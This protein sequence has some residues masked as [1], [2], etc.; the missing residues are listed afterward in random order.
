MSDTIA[1]VATAR[2]RAALGIIRLSGEEAVSVAEAVFRPQKGGT[3]RDYGPHRL[4]LG[5]AVDE[6]D[7]VLDQVLCTYALAPRSFTGEDTAELQCHGSPAALQELLRTLL[8]QGARMAGPGEFSRRA[9]LNGRLDLSQAE[10]IMDLIDAETPLGVRNAALQLGGAVTR[11]TEKVYELLL[12]LLAHFQAVV[13]YP[14]EG[15]EPLEAAETAATLEEAAGQLETLRRS[16]E[17]GKLLKEGVKC[18]IL[19]RPNAGKSSLLN[20]LLGYERAIVTDEA[21]TTR[22][23][24]EEKLSLGGLLL[25]L[26]DTAGLRETYS[27]AEAEGVRRAEAAAEGAGLVLAVFDASRPL[28]PED[29]RVMAAAAAA[30]LSLAVLNKADLPRC[31]DASALSGQFQALVSLSA[32]TGEG[33]EDLE[34]AIV[35]LLGAEDPLPAGEIL[36]NERQYDAI[37]RAQEAIDRAAAALREGFTPDAVLTDAEEALSALGELSGRT[38]REDIIE[39][40]FSRFCVGK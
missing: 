6:E 12:G 14:E 15:V 17:R 22:D 19:G 20:A 7:R 32:K 29:R 2:G 25:R 36:T 37:L 9:F 27:A 30:P 18:A 16:F 11:K 5:A 1:A 40:V 8:R 35:R 24:L 39:A 10:A 28:Q 26:T 34:K 3:L 33:L 21:G 31:L 23:T 38:L 4:V 13:D